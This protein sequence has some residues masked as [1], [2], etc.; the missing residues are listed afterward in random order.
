MADVTVTVRMTPAEFDLVRGAL[1][2][3]YDRV[4]EVRKDKNKSA[5]ARDMASR[6]SAKL[7]LVLTKF[8]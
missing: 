1:Q 8:K 7:A 3:E 5:I 4:C 6:H 2:E